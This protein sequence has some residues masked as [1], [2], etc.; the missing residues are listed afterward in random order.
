MEPRTETPPQVE[1]EIRRVKLVDFDPRD[2]EAFL[3]GWDYH[4]TGCTAYSPGKPKGEFEQWGWEFTR[5]FEDKEW[6]LTIY[7]K[8]KDLR[9]VTLT[10]WSPPSS[11]ERREELK[12]GGAD[13]VEFNHQI[14]Q[15]SFLSKRV[16]Y[17]ISKKGLNHFIRSSDGNISASIELPKPQ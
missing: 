9:W 13:K 11:L 12:I 5:T 2:A 15:L 17:H 6:I 3:P 7:S 1:K 8:R 4:R 10:S 16:A 14:G